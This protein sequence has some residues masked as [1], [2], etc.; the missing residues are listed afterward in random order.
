MT[1]RICE[2]QTTVGERRVETPEQPKRYVT[3]RWSIE[4]TS[5]VSRGHVL[6][7]GTLWRLEDS[8]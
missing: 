7:V 6:K 4:E 1:G 8:F 2:Q 3:Q 5:C